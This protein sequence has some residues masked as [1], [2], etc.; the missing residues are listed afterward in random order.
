MAG[1]G[2]EQQG[3]GDAPALPPT[4]QSGGQDARRVDDEQVAGRKQAGQ[5]TDRFV[6][7]GSRIPVEQQEL[8][9]VA[10]GQGP[11]RDALRGQLEAEVV[12]LDR[13]GDPRGH[14]DVSLVDAP[15]SAA[16]SASDSS[17]AS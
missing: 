2:T 11:L 3:F 4:A 10:L 5:G 16:S 6:P 8:R 12:E 15:P 13:G 7:D 17:S 9:R 14:G 1:L